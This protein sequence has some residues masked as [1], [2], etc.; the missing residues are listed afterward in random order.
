MGPQFVNSSSDAQPQDDQPNNGGKPP[1]HPPSP[2]VNAP[3]KVMFDAAYACFGWIG[4]ATFGLSLTTIL[5]RN[6]G[7]PIFMVFWPFAIGIMPAA[8]IGAVLTIILWRDWPLR[9]MT[10]LGV[11]VAPLVVLLMLSD[12]HPELISYFLYPLVALVY[13][14]LTLRWWFVIR[15]RR[16]WK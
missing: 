12:W 9:L 11:L 5:P 4:I 15:K 13:L 8:V 10:I 14:G 2:S 16:I 7:E 3:S 1:D 6:L